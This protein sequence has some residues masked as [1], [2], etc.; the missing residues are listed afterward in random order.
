M[1]EDFD[2]FLYLQPPLGSPTAIDGE[3]IEVWFIAESDYEV[4][5]GAKDTATYK[6]ELGD[7]DTIPVPL[8]VYSGVTD[9]SGFV[10]TTILIDARNHGAGAF[11]FLT[12]YLDRW[13][14]SETVFISTP[15]GRNA[16][17]MKPIQDEVMVET[18]SFSLINL[19]IIEN[20]ALALST[21]F[22]SIYISTHT[23][24]SV[25]AHKERNL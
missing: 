21:L 2:F 17:V 19:A 12:F 9:A 16:A 3:A 22:A 24:Y 23:S 7:I 5:T 20:E 4:Y 18:T 11:V 15:P 6:T 13:N 8:I 10:N 1:W 25:M 14:A